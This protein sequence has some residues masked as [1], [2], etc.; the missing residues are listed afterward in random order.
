[1]YQH[2]GFGISVAL[3]ALSLDSAVAEQSRL[4]EIIE[5]PEISGVSISPDGEF[6]AFRVERA[7][8]DRNQYESAWWIVSLGNDPD[9]REVADGG[10]P[11]FYD[12]GFMGTE[13]PQWSQDS[14]WLYFRAL[15]NGQL[16]VWRVAREGGDPQRVTDDEADVAAYTLGP[17]NRLIYRAQAPRDEI[18]QAE[19]Q[20]Y[21]SGILIDRRVPV[22]QGLFR[23]GLVRGEMRSQR[24]S[25]EWMD[26]GNLLHDHPFQYWSVEANEGERYAASADE[27]ALLE[28]AVPIDW[29]DVLAD[30]HRNA[31]HQ[32]G[33]A[34]FSR[35][36]GFYDEVGYEFDGETTLCSATIC[37]RAR[38]PG[39]AWRPDSRELIFT[40][41]ERSRGLNQSLWS[42]DIDSGQVRPIV[43]AE[44]RLDG[45]REGGCAIGHVVAVCVAAE[46]DAPPRAE[47]VNLTSGERR[48][49]HAPARSTPFPEIAVEA[50]S[51]SDS[52]GRQFTGQLFL[53]SDA[54]DQPT[55]LVIVYYLC[56][57]FVRG[58]TGDEW[59]FAAL[60]DA[61]LA[62]LCINMQS[63]NPD[64][65]DSLDYYRT[66]LS[67]IE[68]VVEVLEGR[69]LID[70]ARV[71]MGGLSFGSEVAYWTAMESDL[72]TTISLATPPLTPT[73]YWLNS[74]RGEEFRSTLR[75]AWGLGRPD[76]EPD[77]WHLLSP[78]LRVEDI[79]ASV[80]MQ[81]PEQEYLQAMEFHARMVDA[82][83]PAFLYVFPDE[84]HIKVQPR[85]RLTVYERN[86]DWFRYWLQGFEDSDPL[87]E[88]QY[89][90]WR[91]QRH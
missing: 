24:V 81:L 45:G 16:Q 25:G 35:S 51:W 66:A 48:I 23:S 64:A 8:V 90:L 77:R 22:G 55:P 70:P 91:A 19:L 9:P 59:P 60:A 27:I 46:A 80:L 30:R 2:L 82:S 53:P 56:S 4:V 83:K 6:A 79:D 38:V 26:L 33:R 62:G 75:S 49:L 84:P 61:G 14:Q 44:G 65:Q 13:I 40:T 88:S 37:S 57:G 68:A 67:G 5:V 1:M 21:E 86:I 69:G 47:A 89:E 7:S 17:S 42:W 32:D 20:E 3:T 72:L 15:I 34:A 12:S 71:G 74:I 36:A 63:S 43:Q 54:A 18:R 58:G 31:K 76:L 11:D 52:E 29:R 28:E 39:V 85:R 78:A 87:K 41:T 50:L 10:H 73:Y